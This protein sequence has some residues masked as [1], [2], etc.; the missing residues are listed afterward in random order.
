[1]LL[2]VSALKELQMRAPAYIIVAT[3]AVLTAAPAQ[4]QAYDPSYPVCMQVYSID[5]EYIECRYTS[6]A[7]CAASASGRAAMCVTNR[8]HQMPL[9]KADRQAPRSY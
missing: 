2:Q 1:M 7:Q 8:Y 3:A 6:L 5:G 9:G 4:A